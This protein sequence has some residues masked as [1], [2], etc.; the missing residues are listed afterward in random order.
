MIQTSLSWLT[1]AR[2]QVKPRLLV[3][4]SRLIAWLLHLSS[5]AKSIRSPK[6][7]IDQPICVA[8]LN[9]SIK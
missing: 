4:T 2:G 6:H 5:I 1:L 3:F 8:Y 7:I 9:E